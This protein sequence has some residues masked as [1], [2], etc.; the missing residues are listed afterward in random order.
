MHTVHV[1]LKRLV[2]AYSPSFESGSANACRYVMVELAGCVNTPATEGDSGEPFVYR[3]SDQ[4]IP[5][6]VPQDITKVQT[7]IEKTKNRR[8][9][10]AIGVELSCF[11]RAIGHRLFISSLVYPDITVI[12]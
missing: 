5:L 8:V 11:F 2:L 1:Q 7:E 3:Q 10:V 6:I 12:R 4:V 9:V